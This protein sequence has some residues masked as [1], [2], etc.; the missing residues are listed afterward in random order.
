MAENTAENTNEMGDILG[1]CLSIGEK[2]RGIYLSLSEDS[3]DRKLKR[4]WKSMSLDEEKHIQFWKD[5]VQLAGE[6]RIQQIFDNPGKVREELGSVLSKIEEL[7]ERKKVLHRVSDAFIIAYR[8]EFHTLHPAFERLFHYM[9]SLSSAL[10]NPEDEYESHINRLIN[11]CNEY[12]KTTPEIVLLGETIQRL[13]IDNKR[14]A[15]QSDIDSLTGI[16]N[17]RGLFRILKT[18][19]F[20]AQRHRDNVGVMMIDI[21]DF[22][23]INDTYGHQKGDEVIKTVADIIR[24]HTRASDVVGRYG[25][26][27]FLVFLSKVGSKSFYNIAEHIRS[28]VE[29]DKSCGVPVTI[30]VGISQKV[31]KQDVEKELENLI[32]EADSCLF[33]AKQGEKNIVKMDGGCP[34]RKVS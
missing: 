2:A 29:N 10:E 31:I 16:Y 24:L 30:S 23:S 9:S 21:D 19:S 11:A 12:G 32:R 3:R 6:N 26:E 17:R 7:S 22:K 1:L 33:S 4:F 8:L 27:E 5:L 14:L 34:T 20:L 15:V 25:G 13:W 28:A 18:M